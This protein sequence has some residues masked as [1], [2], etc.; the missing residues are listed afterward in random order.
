MDDFELFA[1][2]DRIQLASGLAL[3]IHHHGNVQGP[4][5]VLMG[6]FQRE[7]FLTAQV[8]GLWTCKE[9]WLP[10][11]Q[12]IITLDVKQQCH[13]VT[14]DNRG[15]GLSDTPSGRCSSGASPL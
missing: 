7:Y 3:G 9:S 6:T 15:V 1:S 13:M 12:N 5:K 4:E 8:M 11:V 2:P 14:F 10:T